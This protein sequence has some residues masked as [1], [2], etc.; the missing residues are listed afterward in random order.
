MKVAELKRSREELHE[1]KM[2]REM[3]P[4]SEEPHRPH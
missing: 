4:D 3:R 2:V 1:M